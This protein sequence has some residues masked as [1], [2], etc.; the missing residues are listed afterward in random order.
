MLMKDIKIAV[1]RDIIYEQLLLLA[2]VY[3]LFFISIELVIAAP[4]V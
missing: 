1:T 3:T 4:P 2:F